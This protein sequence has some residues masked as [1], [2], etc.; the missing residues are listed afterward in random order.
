MTYVFSWH[1][2]LVMF[3]LKL[4]RYEQTVHSNT[5]FLFLCIGYFVI[6]LGDSDKYNTEY[7]V[8]V[9]IL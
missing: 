6:C 3:L 9:F 1:L 2:V 4:Y 7:S 8:N 5:I